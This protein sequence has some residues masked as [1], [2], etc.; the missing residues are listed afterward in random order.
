MDSDLYNNVLS[1]YITAYDE[2]VV[3]DNSSGYSPNDIYYLNALKIYKKH[4]SSDDIKQ[5]DY[6]G[7]HNRI[8]N[9]KNYPL[10]DGY[11]GA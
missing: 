10:D 6:R 1:Q 2:A 5:F 9:N 7:A 8:V 3:I 11:D 4:P